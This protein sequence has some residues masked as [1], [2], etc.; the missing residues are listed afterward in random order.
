MED[1]RISSLGNKID[2]LRFLH[3]DISKKNFCKESGISTSTLN[4]IE[5][6]I[7][8]T[9]DTLVK[10]ADYF[11]VTVDYLL[12]RTDIPGPVYKDIDSLHLSEGGRYVL[13]SNDIYGNIMSHLLENENFR[14]LVRQ[15]DDYFHNEG[16]EASAINNL[17]ADKTIT[18][19]NE[20]DRNSSDSDT[21]PLLDER[22][23]DR[24]EGMKTDYEKDKLDSFARKLSDILSE[25]KSS[26]GIDEKKRQ[27]MQKL[28]VSINDI[29]EDMTRSA[30]LT[31]KISVETY[32][33]KCMDVFK[34]R[35]ILGDN[36]L[37]YD[38][39]EKAFILMMKD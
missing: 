3:G 24:L 23:I 39:L 28:T 22:I 9:L 29:A 35:Q 6:G 2:Y 37:T 26:Y 31:Q 10:I 12:D 11:D 8:P 32:V 18:G 36:S 14:K 33:S 15:I 7:T 27:R 34:K 30:A 17:L 16:L 4:N 19:I 25:I 5:N 13:E 38:Y 20:I 1:K 21:S